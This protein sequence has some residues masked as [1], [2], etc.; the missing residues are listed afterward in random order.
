MTDYFALLEQPRSPWLDPEQLKQA[1]HAKTLR[2]HPDAQPGS[3]GND[4]AFAQLNEAYQI[5][6][7]PK[8]RL[9]HLLTLAGAS[10]AGETANIPHEI[11]ELF[12]AVAELTKQASVVVQKLASASTS[13]T[14]SLL[15]AE[16][17]RTR[18]AIAQK[19]RRLETLHAA[20][21]DEL[22]SLGD[23]SQ[24]NRAALQQL[25]V[26]FSYLTRWM[27]ELQEKQFDLTA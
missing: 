19:L 17:W 4:E 3:D 14:R 25:Y 13:L 20:A 9:H 2:E 26:R 27:T 18:D 16:L 8:R 21:E 6:R 7:E 23:S 1:F 24:D 11:E 5:L 10:P 12:P 22:R 15:Q